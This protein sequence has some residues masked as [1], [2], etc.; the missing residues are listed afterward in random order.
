MARI[1]V[2]P[3]K[4]LQSVEQPQQI[5]VAI[6]NYIPFIGGYYAQSLDVLKKCLRSIWEHTNIAYDLLVFDNGSCSEVRDYLFE[7][8]DD[9]KIQ[10]LVLSNKNIGKAGA[11]NYIFSAAPGEFIAYADSDVYFF[12]G[13]LEPQIEV[14]KIFPNAGMVT[15]MP[16]WSPEE[17]STSTIRWADENSDIRLERGKLLPWEDYWRHARSLGRGENQARENYQASEDI[18]IFRNGVR[19]YIGAAHFQFVSRKEIL[20]TVLPIP[21]RKPMGE[22]RL[23]DVA[24]NEKR[25]L[26]LSTNDLRVQHMGNVLDEKIGLPTHTSETIRHRGARK[27]WRLKPVRKLLQWCYHRIFAILQEQ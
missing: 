20:Q 13:W 5:T 18:V 7:A 25:Y 3:A 11:W 8:Q 27:I 15:G 22:V 16:L 24:L 6:V 4:S 14:L 21:S 12:S 26:R 17:F 23:L 19:Y 1:G 9:G 10:Y 2:N